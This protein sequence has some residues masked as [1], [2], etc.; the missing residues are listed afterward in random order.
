[1]I[2]KLNETFTKI[3]EVE[4]VLENKSAHTSIEVVMAEGMPKK[5]T[6]IDF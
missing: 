4:G 5:G 1:M 2:Y 6:G 3:G